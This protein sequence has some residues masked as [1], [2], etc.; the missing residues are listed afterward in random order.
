MD[1]GTNPNA[2][3]PPANLPLVLQDLLKN[4]S[5]FDFT[6]AVN[7]LHGWLKKQNLPTSWLNLKYSAYLSLAFPNADI[8]A[9]ESN[10]DQE[11]KVFGNFLAIY[12]STSPLPNYYTEALFDDVHED[13]SAA[14]DFLDLFQHRLYEIYYEFYLSYQLHDESEKSRQYLQKIYALA[15][16]GA[17]GIHSKIPQHQQLRYANILSRKHRTYQGLSTLLTDFIGAPVAIE[18]FVLLQRP[19]P[20]EQYVSLGQLNSVLGET[21]HIG[22][23]Y[24]SARNNLQLCLTQLKL[25]TFKRLLPGQTLSLAIMELIKTYILKPMHIRL[26]L[27]LDGSEHTPANLDYTN[28]SILGQD[29]WL[30]VTDIS[31]TLTLSYQLC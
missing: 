16:I 27:Q 2:G 17:I 1:M 8:K 4:P 9:I 18:P 7:L 12:G 21:M 13:N 26:R 28:P 14:R 29:A 23:S 6:A 3:H 31:D 25:E 24:E 30:G 15:G 10:N 11:F 20:V 19:I 5:D 22:Q